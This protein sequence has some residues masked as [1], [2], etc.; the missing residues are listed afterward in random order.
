MSSNN[1]A[2]KFPN[3]WSNNGTWLYIHIFL[4]SY[5]NIVI[6]S[7]FN[8]HR[9]FHWFYY[10][11]NKHAD[12]C[13]YL[14]ICVSVTLFRDV[15]SMIIIHSKLVLIERFLP[16]LYS[17]D[18]ALNMS[19]V[20]QIIICSDFS[21]LINSSKMLAFA[22]RCTAIG[23]THTGSVKGLDALTKFE[24]VMIVELKWIQRD[25]RTGE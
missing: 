14:C 21:M 5:S 6:K 18:A 24:T 9:L 25:T 17:I 7:L 4:F 8:I 16:L 22:R 13:M 10:Q 20:D 23:I 15:I 12:L 2:I 3:A 19:S 1:L 11:Y